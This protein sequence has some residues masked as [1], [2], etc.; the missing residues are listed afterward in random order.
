MA[1]ISKFEIW[2]V[3]I[4]RLWLKTF[5]ASLSFCLMTAVKETFACMPQP[6]RLHQNG[7]FDVCIGRTKTSTDGLAN[8][9]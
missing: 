5:S 8:Q 7:M 3:L 6:S 4:Q 9:M 2:L 1:E